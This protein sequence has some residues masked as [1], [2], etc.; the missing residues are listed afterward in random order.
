MEQMFEGVLYRQI[1]KVRLQVSLKY[2]SRGSYSH[3]EH[4]VFKCRWL[5]TAS[6]LPD[7]LRGHTYVMSTLLLSQSLGSHVL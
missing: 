5:S 6:E 4:P 1:D 2:R 3:K 7:Q